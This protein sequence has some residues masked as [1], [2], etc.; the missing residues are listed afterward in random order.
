LETYYLPRSPNKEALEQWFPT[1]GPL[2]TGG[3]RTPA[4]WP[5]SKA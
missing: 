4:R 5:T 1:C 2:T 3:T